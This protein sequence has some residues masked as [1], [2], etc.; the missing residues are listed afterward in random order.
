VPDEDMIGV[1]DHVVVEGLI[2]SCIFVD[3]KHVS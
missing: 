3:L 1:L 2:E